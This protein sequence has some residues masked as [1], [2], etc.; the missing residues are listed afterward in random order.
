MRRRVGA[1][2]DERRRQPGAHVGLA[3]HV[4]QRAGAA[5]GPDDD[6]EQ[7]VPRIGLARRRDLAEALPDDRL[8]VARP[9]PRRSGMPSNVGGH[10]QVLPPFGRRPRPP[11]ACARAAP[12]PSVAP[13][14]RRCRL[15]APTAAAPPPGRVPPAVYGYIV[16]DTFWPPAAASDSFSTASPIRPQ[17]ARAPTLRWKI[18]TGSPPSRPMRDAPRRAR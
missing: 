9:A 1:D 4:V 8:V 10:Q 7:D 2:R 15:P 5:L 13:A 6:V 18:T 17:L 16:A 14:S 3:H 11:C 12:D